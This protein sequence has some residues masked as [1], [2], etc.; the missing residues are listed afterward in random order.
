MFAMMKWMWMKMM[1]IL[2]MHEGQAM[3]GIHPAD[4]NWTEWLENLYHDIFFWGLSVEFHPGRGLYQ[5]VEVVLLCPGFLQG[6]MAKVYPGAST[7][8]FLCTF[9][10]WPWLFMVT[11]RMLHRLM[12]RRIIIIIV[13]GYQ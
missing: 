8:C 6:S 9:Y 5:M 1:M 2:D 12:I 13:A 10:S 11:S 3:P 7:V 4:S